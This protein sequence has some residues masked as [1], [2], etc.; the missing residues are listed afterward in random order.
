MEKN[1]FEASFFVDS[2]SHQI[3]QLK[4]VKRPQGLHK[5]ALAKKKKQRTE[6]PS[7]NGVAATKKEKKQ[8]EQSEDEEEDA[9]EFQ[10]QLDIDVDPNNELECLYAMYK[11]YEKAG[12]PA[13]H[14][15]PLIHTSDNIM[16]LHSKKLEGTEEKNEAID[17][18]PEILPALFH[19]IYANSLLAM[20]RVVEDDDDEEEEG[21]QEEEKEKKKSKKKEEDQKDTSKDFIEAALERVSRGIE[22][23]PDSYELLFT[24]ARAL[25]FQIGEKLKRDTLLTFQEYP[26]ELLPSLRQSQAD[27]EAAEALVLA[28]AAA[29][30]AANEK[31]YTQQEVVTLQLLGDVAEHIGTNWMLA[32]RDLEEEE[33]EL[34]DDDEEDLPKYVA[35]LKR[36]QDACLDWIKDRYVN[37]AKA[38]ED[39]KGKSQAQSRSFLLQR[40]ANLGI[41]KYFLAKAAPYIEEY[42]EIMGEDDYDEDEE[43]EKEDEEDEEKSAKAKVLTAVTEKAREYMSKSVEHLLKAENDED[44]DVMALIAEAQVS[45]ANLLEDEAEQEL[46]YEEACVRL[47][48]AQRLGAGD[49]SEMIRELKGH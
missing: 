34:N 4:M 36:L 25:I 31:K 6:A 20:S 44:G 46:L 14:L 40:E 1:Q 13:K 10:F 23:H 45:L 27:F 9:P 16:R 12:F 42:E 18:I 5:A 19:N 28:A 22:E 41:G 38:G 47:K 48:R 11:A 29:A 32:S 39:S 21:E 8:V 26:S 3:L 43:K 7:D 37:M 35:D 49:F 30:D 24:R 33:E 2:E 17:L 15:F